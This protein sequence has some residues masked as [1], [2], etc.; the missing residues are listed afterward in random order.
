[1]A[2]LDHSGL[3]TVHGWGTDG[4]SPYIAMEY[5][6]GGSTSA[7]VRRHGDLKPDNVLLATDGSSRVSDFGIARIAHG[8]GLTKTG[9]TIGTVGSMS[10]EPFDNPRGVDQRADVCGLGATLWFWITGSVPPH[11]FHSDP[12]E[13]GIPGPLCPALER[14]TAFEPHQRQDGLGESLLNLERAAAQLPPLD[15]SAPSLAPLPSD[16][17]DPPT[18]HTQGGEDAPT[19]VDRPTVDQS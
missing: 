18:L 6:P 1:M 3:L 15:S 10:P 8:E 7:R 2:S 11:R 16:L 12:W 14:D 5:A 4:M 9:V 19:W 13:A 17:S